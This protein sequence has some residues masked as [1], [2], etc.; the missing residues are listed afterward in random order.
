MTQR[1]IIKF[2]WT[3]FASFWIGILI[4]FIAIYYG[5]IGYMPPI[6]DLQ[7][8]INKYASQIISS[9]GEVIGSFAQQG[10]NRLYVGISEISPNVIKALEATEDKRFRDH[11]GIDFQAL[12][13]VFFKTVVLGNKN[14]GG[15]STIT[16]QLAKQLYSNSTKNTWERFLQKPIEWVIAIKLERYYT[17]D[18]IIAMYLNQFDFLYNAVGIKMAAKTYFNKDPKDLNIEEAAMLV[19]MCKNPS[20]YNPVLRKNS[21]KPKE[22]R[23]VVLSLMEDQGYI[24]E[25]ELDSLKTLPVKTNFTK[26]AHNTGMAMYFRDYIRQIMM[27]KKPNKDDY[28]QWQYQKYKDDSIAWE[29]DP[30][31][32]WCYKN[33]K[34][35]G[36][37]YNIYTDGLKIHT[38][39][40]TI[41]QKY[42]EEALNKHMSQFIQPSFDAEQRNS[43]NRPF[44]DNVSNST[45]KN[46]LERAIRQSSRYI[47]AKNEGLSEKE[48]LK[49]FNKKTE[50]QVWSWHGM[51]DTVMTPIDSIK[52]MKGIMRAGFMAMN[53]HNGYVLAYVGGIDYSN[54]KYDMVSLGRRQIGSTIKPMLYSLSM[55]EGFSPCDQ[56]LHEQQSITTEDGKVWTPRNASGK[57]IGEYVSI[58]WGLQNSDNWVTAYLMSRTSTRTFM[59]IL[60]S[61]G[62]NGQIDPTPSMCL[63]TPDASVKEMTAAYT[64]FVNKGVRVNPVFVT[65]IVDKMGN[66]I[67]NFSPQTTEVLPEDA[68]YKMNIMMQSV[69]NGG[70]GSRLRGR[71]GLKMPLGGKTG[72]TQ[73]NSDGWFVGF[74]PD[75]VA[76]CWVGG[77]E[78]TIHFRSMSIGQGAASAL[79]IFAEFIKKVYSDKSLGYKEDVHFDIPQGF[80]PCNSSDDE[81]IL[82]LN[83][84]TY[85][86]YNSNDS[87]VDN[88]FM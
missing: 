58:Q 84:D 76:G 8:P 35:D 75:I 53:P 65:S 44:A 21:S 79:P 66:V 1:K 26:I 18:E 15:G 48:I 11:S 82:N 33:K 69:I 61:F 34:P 25:R 62:L 67:A 63:G 54:F 37:Y 22:R 71:Y 64:T 88:D 27:A 41:M 5:W 70:T 10:D 68:S 45:I 57:R 24:S 80:N 9:D 74:T 78:P 17:K 86:E 30:L 83:S 14:A 39:L 59:N 85:D 72:T 31:Y 52:Y 7:N 50:M 47:N 43:I 38:S 51:I 29:T 6:E 28:S 81:S 3:L 16:Q 56:V 2:L 32:G 73:S 55:I 19:G 49:E 36:S 12:P 60:R 42:A 40:N 4:A 46:S 77:D 87:I 13:R 20:I 23:N